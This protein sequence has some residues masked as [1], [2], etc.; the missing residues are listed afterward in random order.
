MFRLW[1]YD[2]PDEYFCFDELAEYSQQFD[3]N[4]SELIRKGKTEMLDSD[5]GGTMSTVV[6]GVVCV[7]HQAFSKSLSLCL[8][9]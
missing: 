7:N 8:D 5:V 2:S 9:S 4:T 1:F 3:F 6:G